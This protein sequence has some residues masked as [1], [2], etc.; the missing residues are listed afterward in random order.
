MP[1]SNKFTE[2]RPWLFA[3]VLLLGVLAAYAPVWR[4]GFIWDDDMYVT[5]NRL[6]TAP[7]GL[8]RIWFSRDAP[9]QYF[10]LTYTVFRAERQL[11]GLNPVGYHAVNVLIHALNALLLW[12]LLRRLKIPG[13]WFG[14]AIFALHP[15]NVESVAWISELKNVLSLLFYLLALRAWVEFIKPDQAKSS[16]YYLLALAA[17]ALALAAKTT[18]CTLP[19]AL[20]LL[21]WLQREPLNLRRCLQL[22]PFAALS[23]AMAAIAIWWERFHQNT[24]GAAFQIAWPERFLIASRALWFYAGKLFWPAHLT[25]IY[26][27]WQIDRH[28]LSAWLWPIVTLF[29]A[30]AVFLRRQ[31]FPRG[32]LVAL[33]FYVAALSPLLGFVMEYTFRYTFVADHYQYIAAIAPCALIAAILHWGLPL[34]GKNGWPIYRATQIVLLV[35]LGCLTA[36]QA[37]IYRDS[38]TLWRANIARNPSAA[39]SHNNLAVALLDQR[40]FDDALAECQLALSLDPS[41]ANA[42]NNCGLALLRLNRIADAIPQFAKAAEL[43]PGNPNPPYN[44][45]QAALAQKD[46]AAAENF[47]DKAVGLKPD[48]AEAFC[49]LGF[50]RLQNNRIPEAIAAYETALQLDPD[51]ALAHNDLGSIYERRSQ[52]NDALLHFQRAVEIMPSFLEAQCNLGDVLLAL[53]R[54]QEGIACY[55][56]ALQIK[57]GYEPAGARLRKLRP[58]Q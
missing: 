27:H 5:Q 8:A 42:H 49:N 48:F 41:D 9:S 21:L 52:L 20:L 18:A 16:L 17:A 32:V 25:F 53:G 7:D 50:A 4:A 22:I 12:R 19:A 31:F 2:R 10:P 13:A 29:F 45:G 15:V 55:Q 54:Q 39:I 38:E 58:G 46:F 6:L 28:G 57:P 23:A 44:L 34:C 36:A 3:A 37:S 40:R 56:K 14:A 11:W 51:Y 35:T 47:F 26:P 24:V 43:D 33:L 30:A 1:A